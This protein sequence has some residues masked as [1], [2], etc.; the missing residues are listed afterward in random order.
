MTVDILEVILD[1]ETESI[2]PKWF[3]TNG[4]GKQRVWFSERKSSYVQKNETE[5]R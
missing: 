1:P 2:L 4:Y 5:R 3:P